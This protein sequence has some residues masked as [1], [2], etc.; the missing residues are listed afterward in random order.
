MVTEHFGSAAQQ[1]T[2]K[3]D[4]EAVR[5]CGNSNGF[6]FTTRELINSLLAGQRAPLAKCYVHTARRYTLTLT[7]SSDVAEKR[8]SVGLHRSR[9]RLERTYHLLKEV[10]FQI[11]NRST[12]ERTYFEMLVGVEGQLRGVPV[13]ITYQPNWWFEVILNLHS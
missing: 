4:F 10:H 12:G 8:I 13:Q 9:N 6:L 5:E 2:R 7:R 11:E 3:L 1:P